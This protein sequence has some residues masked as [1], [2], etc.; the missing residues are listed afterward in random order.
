MIKKSNDSIIVK[1][2][3]SFIKY[4]FFFSTLKILFLLLNTLPTFVFWPD[5]SFYR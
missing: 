5:S 4:I 1:S 2:I 3:N